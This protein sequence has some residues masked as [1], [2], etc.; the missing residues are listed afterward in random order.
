MKTEEIALSVENNNKSKN[1]DSTITTIRPEKGTIMGL[2]T[3]PVDEGK[4]IGLGKMNNN[5]KEEVKSSG[6]EYEDRSSNKI[7]VKIKD[8]D[9][10]ESYFNNGTEKVTNMGADTEVTKVEV[11]SSGHNNV[12]S[13]NKTVGEK[14]KSNKEKAEENK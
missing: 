11:Q 14:S 1:N 2:N 13:S 3:A 8:S 6:K 10:Q 9:N 5:N 7:N 4:D 12:E